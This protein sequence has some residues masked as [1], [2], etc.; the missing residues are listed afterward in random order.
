[1]FRFKPIDRAIWSGQFWTGPNNDWKMVGYLLA[2]GA[3]YSIT[4]AAATGDMARVQQLLGGDAE[5][6]ND[7]QPCGRNP[8]SAAVQFGHFDIAKL[9][10]E[11]G[12]DPKRPEG[13]YA[14]L[15]T[16]LYWATKQ[17]N[18]EMTRVLL[19]K[20]A[21]P[22]AYIDSSGSAI[23]NTR[24]KAIRTLLYR[25]GAT[26]DAFQYLW[27]ENVDAIALMAEMDPE[28]VGSSGCGGAFAAV[29]K[30]GDR[31][32]FD[33]LLSK[34]V[35]V[36]DV[37]TGCRT[38]LW[39]RPEMTRVLLENGMNPNL[40]GDIPWATPLAWAKKRGHDRIAGILRQHGAKG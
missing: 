37:V 38:Y 27:E 29:V 24:D 15:G 40:P 17:N 18:R 32:M 4:I 2:R 33:L 9:L 3:H 1:M 11:K 39:S 35:R 10:L 8:L 14:P 25:Y 30:K 31:D 20:G 6:V 19:E 23:T 28:K 5:L 34:G 36:P 12:A 13:R 26:I 21:A 7:A 22:D 16:A